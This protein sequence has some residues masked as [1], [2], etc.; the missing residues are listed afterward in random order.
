[1]ADERYRVRTKQGTKSKSKG[2][3]KSEPAGARAQ[4]N[5]LRESV[6]LAGW[7]EIKGYDLEKGFNASEFIDS[8]KYTGLQATSLGKAIQLVKNMRRDKAKIF[9][10]FTSNMITSGVREYIKYLV[11][12][13]QV[14]VLVTTAGG[15]EEDII[16]SIRPFVVGDYDAS[17]EA[18]RDKGVNRSGNIFCPNDRYLYFERFM[19]RFLERMHEQQ[20]KT[21]KV[22]NTKEFVYELGRELELQAGMIKQGKDIGID[23]I[24]YES[25]VAYWAYK[26]NT[27][28]YCHPITDGSIGDM[29][30]F[31]KKRKPDF[32]ID[33]TDD[34]VTITDIALNSEKTGIIALGGSV[35][36][37]HIANANLFREG[38]D[39][40]VYINL[41]PE[42]EGSNSGASPDEAVSWG[43]I[44]SKGNSVKVFSEASIVFPLLVIGGWEDM[45]VKG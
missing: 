4:A 15:V 20:V 22:I 45:V 11:K 43:K 39:Y 13:K 33:S 8:L 14:H 40:A 27:P 7:P 32:K 41:S 5:V 28:Y 12:H 38:A 35:P 19:N 6:T 16:K 36:K 23:K 18:L 21:G 42:Y 44:K 10:G 31:F 1:M 24:D 17:G 29:I 3:I 37:H 9:L 34:I 25:S 30:Y 2:K 26:N